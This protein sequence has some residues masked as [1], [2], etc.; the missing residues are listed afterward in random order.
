MLGIKLGKNK[1]DF[2]KL[3]SKKFEVNLIIEKLHDY[4]CTHIENQINSKYVVQIF[5][6]WLVFCHIKIYLIIV[7]YP[8]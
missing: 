3:K 4:L 7:T 5:D 6:S 8:I 2:K 1:M